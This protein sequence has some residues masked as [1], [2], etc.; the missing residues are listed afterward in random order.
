[1]KIEIEVAD[2]LI[3]KLGEEAIRSYLETK[4]EALSHSLIEQPAEETF[5][6]SA[7]KDATHTAWQK[8]NK[9]GLSC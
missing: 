4:T 8:F 2:E 6:P 9:R 5:H 3:E 1:M 7:D